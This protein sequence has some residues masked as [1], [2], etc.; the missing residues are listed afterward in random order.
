MFIIAITSIVTGHTNSGGTPPL[1]TARPEHRVQPPFRSSPA[2][3][4]AREG[5]N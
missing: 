3:R 4:G 2:Q 5:E 1:E